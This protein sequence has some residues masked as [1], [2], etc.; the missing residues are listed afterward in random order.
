MCWRKEEGNDAWLVIQAAEHSW[1]WKYYMQIMHGLVDQPDGSKYF[2]ELTLKGIY[3]NG[4]EKNAEKWKGERKNVKG[5]ENS[6][7]GG[8]GERLAA[9]QRQLRDDLQAVWPWENYLTTLCRWNVWQKL[10]YSVALNV[11][12]VKR[13]KIWEVLVTVTDPQ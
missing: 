5:T 2:G 11:L 12:S 13:V 7:Y 3:T 1:R 6:V 4:W 10:P 8:K 9:F